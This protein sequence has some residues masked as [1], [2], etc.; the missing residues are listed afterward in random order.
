MPHTISEI[1]SV[2]R[3]LSVAI[4]EPRMPPVTTITVLLAPASAWPI[5][6]TSALRLAR[7]SPAAASKGDSAIADMNF[8]RGTALVEKL[9]RSNA[10]G[11]GALLRPARGRTAQK[12]L[13]NGC[14]RGAQ[15]RADAR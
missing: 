14:S 12:M 11:S 7:R 9:R 3:L 5:A 15:R 4:I 10:G 13:K 1:G 2:A 8:L 6:S